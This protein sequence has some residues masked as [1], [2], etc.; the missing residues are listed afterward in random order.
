MLENYGRKRMARAS[1]A[2]RIAATANTKNLLRRPLS[3]ILRQTPSPNSHFVDQAVYSL[4][5]IFNKSFV[6]FP[7][8]FGN[9][10]VEVVVDTLLLSDD[11]FKNLLAE[12]RH[13]HQIRVWSQ[14]TASYC[15]LRYI[16]CLV[17]ESRWSLWG[18]F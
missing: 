17:G 7:N 1:A 11:L 15:V 3:V 9:A 18:W 5:P 14:S 2:Y 4:S 10:V 16:S 13:V 6:G 12:Y 8:Q